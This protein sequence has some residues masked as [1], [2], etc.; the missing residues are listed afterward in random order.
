MVRLMADA[1]ARL[2]LD[3]RGLA[4]LTEAASDAYA[5]TAVLAAMAGARWVYA[6][7]RDTRYG[8]CGDLARQTVALARAAGVVDRV[9]IV[10]SSPHGVAF[11]A[12]IVTNS[13]A[14]RPIE[15][16]VIGRLPPDAVIALMHEAWQFRPGD[17][18]LAACLARQLPVVAVNQ[19]HADVDLFAYVGDLAARQLHDAGFAIRG[20]RIG[21]ICDNAFCLD[22][23]RTLERL[24]GSVWH[25]DSPE[26][27]PAERFD[28]I[29]VAMNPHD[30]PAI[31]SEGIRR[32]VDR[33]GPVPIVQFWGD[34]DRPMLARLGARIWP[35]EA[36]APRHMGILF[37]ALGPEALIRRQAGGLRAAEL[38]YRGGAPAAMP[39]GLAELVRPTV[40]EFGGRA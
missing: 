30:R 5:C 37:P 39:G 36:P 22:I 10:T 34:V 13:G 26:A 16:E 29:L 9:E 8:S 1:L 11:E 4:V 33:Q 2:K 15:A 27:L 25:A 40:F 6:Y 32:L 20:C 35:P 31:D 18:D 3:L 23:C 28:A 24:D 14:L 38:V 19:R 21:V 7:A 17:L 12:Q